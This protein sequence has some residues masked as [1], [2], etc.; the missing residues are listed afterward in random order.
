VKSDERSQPAHHERADE[1]NRIPSPKR[2]L[3]VTALA[4]F[5]GEVLVML[6]LAVLPP[7]PMLVEAF[8]DGTMLTALAAPCLYLFLFRP[9]R[10]HIQVRRRAE[11]ELDSIN[12][13]LKALVAER[14]ESLTQ[15]NR[16]LTHEVEEH[17]R[18]ADSL[19]RN[20]E[21]IEKVVERAPC[22][23]LTFDAESQRCSYANSR[24][25]DLLGYGQ[26]EL[27][28]SEETLVNRLVDARD[29]A[30]FSEVVKELVNGPEGQAVGGSCGFTASSGRVVPL[31]F[32][33]TV[34]S[35]TPTMEAK[36]LLL[37]ALPTSV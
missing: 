21:F 5:V 29:R 24:I 13:R 25:T 26:D 20:N 23:I 1:I 2:L 14:T 33:M 36:D 4:V 37:T 34:L 30:S 32:G 19:R 6:I 10:Q 17:R 22:L 9:M 11:E 16:R 15:T 7:M 28:V 3:I 12:H 18:T 31:R 27:A 8:A 35:R